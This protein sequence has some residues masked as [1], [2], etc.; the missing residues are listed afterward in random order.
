MSPRKKLCVGG[1][2]ASAI[3]VGLLC[4]LPNP[5]AV[6]LT[7][8]QV[9]EKAIGC[10]APASVTDLRIINALHGTFEY[11]YTVRFRVAPADLDGILRSG[12]FTRVEDMPGDTPAD[13]TPPVEAYRWTSE[14]GGM[15]RILH[16]DATRRLVECTF[17]RI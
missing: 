4:L 6:R 13:M 12:H 16:T 9:L 2:I 1:A 3:L 15:R 7:P 14:D 11:R 17:F 5:F 10:P 8:R